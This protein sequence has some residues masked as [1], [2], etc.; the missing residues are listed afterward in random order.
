MNIIRY[1]AVETPVDGY[2]DSIASQSNTKYVYQ[3][4]TLEHITN[5]ADLVMSS[6]AD[7]AYTA[8]RINHRG[9]LHHIWTQRV[10]TNEEKARLVEI[11][12]AD[13]AANGIA[14]P[15]ATV[16][17]THWVSG[18]PINHEFVYKAQPNGYKVSFTRKNTNTMYVKVDN[19]NAFSNI[20]CGTLKYDYSAGST[21]FKNEVKTEDHTVE[22]TW[23]DG[24]DVPDGAEVTIRLKAVVPG[25]P[26]SDEPNPA[27]VP[28]NLAS[29]GIT[30][31]TEILLNGGKQGGDDTQ[32]KPWEY[33]WTDLP[34]YDKDGKKI[35]YSAEEISYKINGTQ[36]D[37]TELVPEVDTN[38]AGK[39]VITNKTPDQS[40]DILKVDKKTAFPLKGAQF[41]IQEVEPISNTS[42]P[43]RVGD[44]A[45]S[46]PETTGDSGIVTFNNIPMGYYEVSE[47]KRPD[48]YIIE[49]DSEFYV[50]VDAGGVSLLE[51]VI[52]DGKLSFKEAQPDTEGKIKV[53]N[54]TFS[55][56]N[57]KIILTVENTAGTELP[58]SGGPG[59]VWIYILGSMLT[60]L[61]GVLLVARKLA[62]KN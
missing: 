32:Q 58:S 37:L 42:E 11:V 51:K 21:N 29:V 53:G 34:Q 15:A 57:D 8:V 23:G 44:A 48:G 9:Y 16:D 12:N 61:G 31:K 59:T 25:T 36:I 17:N 13:L 47:T 46:D 20:C 33:T 62:K 43:T 19:H 60:M 10:P 30:Q 49:G 38:T 50:K 2:A 18:L 1:Y 4:Y 56:L 41:T 55:I 28:I 45:A 52:T 6:D 3:N 54:V 24:N 22:K 5:D 35:T 27:P 26:T 39:T 14:D 40:F 7:L